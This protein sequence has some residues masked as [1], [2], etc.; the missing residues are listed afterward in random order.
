MTIS[1]L[2]TW[3]IRARQM[4]GGHVEEITDLRKRKPREAENLVEIKEEELVRKR[5]K[6]T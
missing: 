4:D 2:K 3:K 6:N 1:G 5:W